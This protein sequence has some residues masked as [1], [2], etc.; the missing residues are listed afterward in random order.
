[1]AN[2]I[3]L[4]LSLVASK[5]GASVNSAGATGPAS[6]T[7]DM[8]G[9]DMLGATQ[10]IDG[11]DAAIV[12]GDV[13]APFYLFAKNIGSAGIIRLGLD[14]PVTQIVSQLD[15]GKPCFLC[16]PSGATIYADTTSG[17]AM[18]YYV[19]VEA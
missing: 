3:N 4:V 7:F 19:A 10:E 9:V 6:L 13:T 1:M 11:T 14:N 5:G 2:E 12:V 15:P 18:L 8:T 17:T 16:V